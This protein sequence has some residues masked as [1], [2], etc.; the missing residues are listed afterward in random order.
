MTDDT[1]YEIVY[2][3]RRRLPGE[4]DFTEVG[5]GVSEMWSTPGECAHMVLS[6]VQ[7]YGWETEAGMPDPD[8]IRAEVEARND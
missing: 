3:L 8:E 5:F 6:A 4:E 1:D 7:N 2:T